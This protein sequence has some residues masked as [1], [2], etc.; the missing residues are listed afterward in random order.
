MH[1]S[2]KKSKKSIK[3]TL[4]FRSNFVDK[5]KE[6]YVLFTEFVFYTY[7]CSVVTVVVKTTIKITTIAFNNDDNVFVF[8]IL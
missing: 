8:L 3:K 4:K 6:I 1:P 7:F 5:V 2:I